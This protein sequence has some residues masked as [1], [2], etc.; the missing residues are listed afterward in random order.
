M[1][2][3]LVLL[4]VCVL[5]FSIIA[6]LTSC[7]G[8][9]TTGDEPTTDTPATTDPNAPVDGTDGTSGSKIKLPT[10]KIPGL[11]APDGE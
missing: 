4:L 10:I 8:K 6:T 9:K 1:K 2:K 11:S 7:G 5:V 3:L